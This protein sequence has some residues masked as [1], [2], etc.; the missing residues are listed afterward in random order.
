MVVA[1]L[2]LDE[3]QVVAVL[4]QVGDVGP[5]QRVELQC[6]IQASGYEAKRESSRWTPIRGPLSD[7]QRALLVECRIPGRSSLIH[8]HS[9]IVPGVQCQT[10]GTLRCLDGEPFLALP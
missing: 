9:S 10:V 4:D 8:I 3:H 6:G 2:L 7:D 5:V 1:D